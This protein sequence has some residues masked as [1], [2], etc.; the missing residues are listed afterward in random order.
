ML[1]QSIAWMTVTLFPH[2]E[3]THEWWTFKSAIKLGAFRL[4][5]LAMAGTEEARSRAAGGRKGGGRGADQACFHG[6][7]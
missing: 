6:H 5:E 3:A 1:F 4:W 2:P 7:R